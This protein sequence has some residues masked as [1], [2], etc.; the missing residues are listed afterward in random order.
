MNRSRN[1]AMAVVAAL[2]IAG[3]G[4]DDTTTIAGPAVS[5]DA[6]P[7]SSG[8]QTLRIRSKTVLGSA[9]LSGTFRITNGSGIGCSEGDFVEHRSTTGTV[10]TLTCT[11]GQRTGAIEVV[12]RDRTQ[13]PDGDGGDPWWITGGTGDFANVRGAGDLISFL[14]DGVDHM[15]GSYHFAEE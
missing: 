12:F 9:P 5:G 14:A 13:T 3:C 7:E 2:A 8:D 1:F 4:T 10:R 15:T 11:S 6:A